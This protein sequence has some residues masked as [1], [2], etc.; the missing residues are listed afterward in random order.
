MHGTL[1]L[2][3]I[4]YPC[5]VWLE[6][7]TVFKACSSIQCNIQVPFLVQL[8]GTILKIPQNFSQPSMQGRL[9][10][11]VV[12]CFPG[13]TNAHELSVCVLAGQSPQAYDCIA[14]VCKPPEPQSLQRV[15]CVH[16]IQAVQGG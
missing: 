10:N 4:E 15:D 7:F 3:D 6:H 8:S 5:A 2:S 1:G 9:D 11:Y 16:T 12:I 14:V 13:T